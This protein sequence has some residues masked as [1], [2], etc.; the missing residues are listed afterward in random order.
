MLKFSSIPFF[1]TYVKGKTQR[2]FYFPLACI[3]IVPRLPTTSLNCFKMADLKFVGA[4]AIMVACFAVIYPRFMHP[5]FLRVFGLN[6][7]PKNERESE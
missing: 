5:L 7:P 3:V 6:D 2:L 1:F 4:V